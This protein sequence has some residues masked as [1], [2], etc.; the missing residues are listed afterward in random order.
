MMSRMQRLLAGLFVLV[1]LL[2]GC[3]ARS[4]SGGTGVLQQ[5]LVGALSG[6]VVG[7]GAP[8]VGAGVEALVPNTTTVIA[9]DVTDNAGQYSLSLDEGTYDLRVT[10]PL[11][12]GFQAELVQ[13]VVVAGAVTQDVILV[14]QGASG[15]SGTLRGADGVPI[16]GATVT[17]NF[18]QATTKTD[19]DGHYAFD[20][21]AGSYLIRFNGGSGG[22]K[23]TS[24]QCEDSISVVGTVTYDLTL[25]GSTVSGAVTA[26]GAAVAGAQVTGSSNQN[27]SNSAK[28]CNSS[29]T[30]STD[31]NGHYS[32]FLLHGSVSI[33][34]RAPTGSSY[35][36]ASSSI[37]A[38]SSDATLDLALPDRVT[39]SGTVR[40]ADGLPLSGATVTA[41]F[42][43]FTTKTDS[44]GNYSFSLTPG[45]YVLRISGGSGALKPTSYQCEDFVSLT[46]ATNYDLTLEGSTVSG[47]VTAGGMAV[48]GSLVNASSN[49][50]TSP[51][52]C[53]SSS[54][55][56]TDSNGSYSV[57]LLHGFASITARAPAGSSYGDRSASISP[58]SAPATLD[59]ALPEKVA[60][61]GTL[62][63]ID[64]VAVAGATVTLNSSQVSTKTDAEGRYTFLL[65]PGSYSLRFSGG[66]GGL[67]PTSYQCS[68]F[69][70]VNAATTYDLTLDGALVTGLIADSNGAPIPNVKISASSSMSSGSKSC[71]S[72]ANV[73]TGTSGAYAL[74]LLK[75]SANFS[76]TPPTGSGFFTTSFHTTLT[77]DVNQAVRLQLADATAPLLVAGPTVV[78]LSDT[79]VSIGWKT[80]EASTSRVE[81]GVG[82]TA[83]VAEV[84][85]LSTD[86]SVTL[87]NLD[88]ATIYS[89][90][91]VSAD[92]SGNTFTGAL[93][94]FATQPP[95][96]DI[97]AP[98]ITVGPAVTFVDAT[99]AIVH[100]ETD[101]PASS[102]VAYGTAT[103][104][105]TIASPPAVFSTTHSVTISG[106]SPS[107]TYVVQVSSTD[108]DG[109]GPTVSAVQ[110]FTTLATPDSA[111]PVIVSG[112]SV[113]VATDTTLTIAW[114]TDEP[115]TSGVSYTDGTKFGVANDPAFTTEHVLTIAGLSPNKTYALSVTSTD[116][117]GNGPAL[118]SLSATTAAAPDTTPPLLDAIAVTA[119]DNT[120]T[121]AWLS[122]E[123][124]T[125]I[126]QFGLTSALGSQQANLDLETSHSLI[127]TGLTKATSY[128][129]V[130][131]SV[132]TAGNTAQSSPLTFMTTGVTDADG[133][134]V[135]DDAD[136]CPTLA[137]P[138]QLDS[139]GDGHGD[140]CVP[141]SVV[142]GPGVTLGNGVVIGA[143]S[144][145]GKDASMADG[146][147]LGAGVTLSSGASVGSN[148]V[149][150]DG[151]IVSKNASVGDNT[152]IG[153]FVT[154]GSGAV[155]GDDVTIG[156]GTI[157]GKNV[158]VIDGA[159]LGKNC[160]V[161]AG[162]VIGAG[163]ILGDNVT[164]KPGALVP[165]GAVIPAGTT[166]P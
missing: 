80:N 72:S 87:T 143:G 37:A 164:V 75:G 29:G 128:T 138:D 109:N 122:D 51:K 140:A 41:N 158:V 73:T 52:R 24:Y 47:M 28:R 8:L 132:D 103:P 155:V 108:P 77:S 15:L 111:A 117:L 150:G 11:S 157:L 60:L 91:I 147:T 16:A 9:A 48:A 12:S 66:S 90:R 61:S 145:L 2:V 76:I 40:G 57:F 110:S 114:T 149:I 130:V 6:T 160:R 89:F 3:T 23:P 20:L 154:V 144:S 133:D 152:V 97:T 107:T 118:A 49:Q 94:T 14:A 63:G 82:D 17:I 156:D 148:S 165:P 104:D 13:D 95:P 32:L 62:R 42:S 115:S 92:L 101:E 44:T 4:D 99:L 18:S 119:D 98:Q 25:A 113:V 93:A 83:H 7:G 135:P 126:V 74:L 105:T 46:A 31:T 30:T 121:I 120:A 159:V 67:K 35:G 88:A 38:F 64:G 153:A 21:A 141:T 78:H 36:D 50:N 58:F 131:L 102:D 162:A 123:P 166:Y 43:Q 55:A 56:T 27:Q 71:S 69:V 106:L 142:L 70:S 116:P 127:L 163:A 53:N 5:A 151:S 96:G 139:N 10:P 19:A 134:G 136:N 26:G 79:S 33:T 100:W 84:A 54:S 1:A 68:D 85:G 137:N 161:A 129:F 39:L 22:L 146:S 45:S 125:S 34:A 124:A 81:Y 86:H 65:T 112:P 59:L